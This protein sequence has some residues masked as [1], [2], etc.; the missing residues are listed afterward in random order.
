MESDDEPDGEEYAKPLSF[1]I[2]IFV[3]CSMWYG[4][5]V[6]FHWYFLN[7]YPKDQAWMGYPKPTSFFGS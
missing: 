1:W 3:F 2:Q 5:M 4:C 7:E 6:W